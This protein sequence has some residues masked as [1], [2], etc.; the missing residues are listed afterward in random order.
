MRLF[1]KRNLT[2]EEKT[3][4]R[5]DILLLSLSGLLLA[6]AFPPLWFHSLIFVGLIPYFIVLEKRETLAEINRATYFMAFIF[7]LFTVYWVGGFTVGKDYYLMISGFVLL[8]F[9]PLLFLIASTLFYF[10]LKVFSRKVAMLL[11]PFFWVCYE[12]CYSLTDFQFPW[13]TLGNSQSKF[14]FFIQ[15]AD[16]V[17]V[18]GLSL[19]ILFSN[20]FFFISYRHY[21]KRS[22]YRIPLTI[23][24][25]L[26]ILPIIYGVIKVNSF[27]ES[28]KKIHVGL[29][30]PDLDPYEKWSGGNLNEIT[31]MYLSLSR[32]AVAKKAELVIWPETALPVYLLSGQYIENLDSIRNFVSASKVSLLTGMPH[33]ISYLKNE[34]TPS[35]AKYS[36][37]GDFYYTNYNAILLFTPE[38]FKIQSYKKMK[39]VPF[40]EHTPFA[41]QLPFLGDL[42]KWGVG[43]G[44][45]NIGKDTVNFKLEISPPKVDYASGE[46]QST[47]NQELTTNINAVVCYESIFPELIAAFAQRGSEM[48]AVVTNDSWYGNTSGPYQH[49]EISVLRAVENRR[50]VVRAA[51]GGISCIIN[52]IGVT[53]AETKMYTKDVLVGTV[54]LNSEKTFYT[55]HPFLVPVTSSVI[56]L[57]VF[58]IF[59]LFKLKAKFKG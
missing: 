38:S 3:K 58:G 21:L 28:E 39:L 29:I 34:K 14:L 51:N 27:K 20:L 37:A 46:T 49:K 9:N 24:L 25:L 2:T 6:L 43:I 41:D 30:Q 31:G 44:G 33:F 36:Q 23:A 22:N 55:L 45:W 17:G 35:D 12:Y 54:S 59:I 47:N 42:I 11:F 53:V 4:K 15:L 32:E 1:Q 10:A 7:S 16:I 50:S 19:I 57:W 52:P 5:K 26:V 48:I 40:G 8:F 18:Y 13:L 56:S